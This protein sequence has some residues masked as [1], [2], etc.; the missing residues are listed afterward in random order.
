[1]HFL[2]SNPIAKE[3]EVGMFQP[4]IR[5]KNPTQAIMSL[6][7]ESAFFTNSSHDC[8][9]VIIEYMENGGNE[10]KKHTV[11][12]VLFKKKVWIAMSLYITPIER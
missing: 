5:S 4:T 1:M 12:S 11:N 6:P 10:L 2:K 7:A 8:G 9:G 3:T